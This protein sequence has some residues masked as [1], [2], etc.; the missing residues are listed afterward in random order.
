MFATLLD[1]LY[2]KPY[3]FIIALIWLIAIVVGAIATA[4]GSVANAGKAIIEFLSS[5]RNYK[6]RTK[7]KDQ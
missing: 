2:D 6:D 1:A 7:D 4:T 5:Y 3:L